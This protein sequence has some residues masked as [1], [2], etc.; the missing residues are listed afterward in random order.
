MSRWR[1]SFAEE[2]LSLD[3]ATGGELHV[4]LRAGFPAERLVFH[5][6][7]KSEVEIAA[8]RDAG[9]GVIVAD[10]FAEIE[11][12]ERLGFGGRVFVRATP[13]VEA[14]THEYIETGTERSKFGFSVSRGD[15]LDRGPPASWTHRR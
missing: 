8:A 15:A 13:G 3:V 9:V 10:S 1:G 7:N 5:G 12:L 4:A 11:R 14:H 2:G 6:N